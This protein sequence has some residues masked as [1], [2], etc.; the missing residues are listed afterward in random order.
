MSTGTALF[1]VAACALVTYVARAG[2]II[3]LADRK[4]PGVVERA[5]QNVAPAVL[6]ALAVNLAVGPEGIGDVEIA[7]VGALLVAA[8]VALK[9]SNLIW[10]FVAGMSTLWILSALT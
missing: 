1:V 4:L 9:R 2:L 3:A 8:L 5:L 10:T 7:E 6:A